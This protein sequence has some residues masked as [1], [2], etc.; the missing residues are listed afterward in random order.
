MGDGEGTGLEYVSEDNSIEEK[1][2]AANKYDTVVDSSSLNDMLGRLS[3][4]MNTK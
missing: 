3:M 2:K 1:K 4:F